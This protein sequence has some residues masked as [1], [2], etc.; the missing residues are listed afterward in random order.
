MQA[1]SRQSP[2]VDRGGVV[3]LETQ[4]GEHDLANTWKWEEVCME[5]AGSVA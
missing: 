3:G 2:D 4:Q 1:H 5:Q